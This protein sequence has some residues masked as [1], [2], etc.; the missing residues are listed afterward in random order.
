MAHLAESAFGKVIV[1]FGRCEGELSEVKEDLKVFQ[2][3]QN[4]LEEDLRKYDVNKKPMEE[5]LSK[6]GEE[7]K[8]SLAKMKALEANLKVA[9]SEY[10]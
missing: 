8:K 4:E 6:L 1:E 7:T 5:M 9:R 10:F 3:K 2:E